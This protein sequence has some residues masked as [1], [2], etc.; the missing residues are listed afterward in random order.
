MTLLQ[1]IIVTARNLRAEMKVDPKQALTGKLYCRPESLGIAQSNLEAIARLALVKV[2][3]LAGEAPK[4]EGAVRK[5]PAFD[6]LLEVPRE[7]AEAQR[8]RV[9]KEIE[10][11]EKVI[12]NSERQ[13]GDEKF[14]AKAPAKVVDGIK[15]KLADYQAQL[16]KHK[17]TLAGL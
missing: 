15:A 7:Q 2:E 5:T 3:A 1:E 12:A 10:Q 8:K 14:L 4:A 9:E 11:L 16:A 6:L 17:E 13:L